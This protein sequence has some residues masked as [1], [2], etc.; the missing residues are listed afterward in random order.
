MYS[1]EFKLL[2][3]FVRAPRYFQDPYYKTVNVV[4]TPSGLRDIFIINEKY[5]GVHMFYERGDEKLENIDIF[6]ITTSKYMGQINLKEFGLS[7]AKYIRTNNKDK[8]YICIDDPN[9]RIVKYKIFLP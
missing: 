1:A 4:E 5:L 8:I 6:E 9:P 3:R 7:S 2:R